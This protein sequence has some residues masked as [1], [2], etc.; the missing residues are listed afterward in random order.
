MHKTMSIDSLALAAEQLEVAIELF[1]SKRSFASAVTLGGAAEEIFGVECR[2][3]GLEPFND[4]MYENTEPVLKHFYGEKN[5]KKKYF[6]EQNAVRNALKHK[7]AVASIKK[8]I[9]LEDSACWMIVRAD[10]NADL[11]NINIKGRDDFNDWFFTNIVGDE[12]A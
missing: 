10:Y 6:N 11:L 2:E 12:Y 9:D 8:A 7:N 1:L 3:Q 4:W 5:T